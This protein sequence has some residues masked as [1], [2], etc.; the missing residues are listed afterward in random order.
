VIRQL[1]PETVTILRKAVMHRD[2]VNSEELLVK[3]AKDFNDKLTR[4]LKHTTR[5]ALLKQLADGDASMKEVKETIQDFSK[6]VK[7]YHKTVSEA[8]SQ[9]A[10]EPVPD[11]VPSSWWRPLVELDRTFVDFADSETRELLQSVTKASS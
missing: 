1:A 2:I 4:N 5:P 11:S 10:S 9:V 3:S 6:R 8:V 7:K